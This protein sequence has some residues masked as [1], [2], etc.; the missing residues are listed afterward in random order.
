LITIA[1]PDTELLVVA[2]LNT[3]KIL[4]LV[5]EARELAK[6]DLFIQ[7]ITCMAVGY[8][9]YMYDLELKPGVS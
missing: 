2:C 3:I 6:I 4:D 1:I 8:I 5:D 7:S 9:P